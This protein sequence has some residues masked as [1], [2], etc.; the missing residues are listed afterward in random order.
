MASRT[1]LQW[2]AASTAAY[3]TKTP[4]YNHLTQRIPKHVPKK[5]TRKS[6]TLLARNW[7]EISCNQEEEHCS[8]P[9]LYCM[10]MTNTRSWGYL[11]EKNHTNHSETKHQPR[12]S[13]LDEKKWLRWRFGP[14]H[15]L[16]IQIQRFPVQS[17]AREKKTDTASDPVFDARHVCWPQDHD[18][19]QRHSN[20]QA[21]VISLANNF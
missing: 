13:L 4:Y 20:H 2:L 14:T 7:I 15:V 19:T 21:L 17:V 8:S 6:H 12:K 1:A 5:C 11:K 3:P 18:G 9:Q 16:D 10:S